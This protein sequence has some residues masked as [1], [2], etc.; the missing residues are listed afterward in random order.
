MSSTA[1]KKD[2]RRL[3]LESWPAVTASDLLQG[4]PDVWLAEGLPAPK[5][6]E[7]V[8]LATVGRLVRYGQSVV[9]HLPISREATLPRLAFYLHRLR[10]DAAQGLIRSPWLNR[11]GIACRADLL[12]F[13]RPRAMLRD[14]VTSTVMRPAMVSANTILEPAEFQ[15]TLLIDGHGDLLGILNM[16]EARSRP[17]AIVVDISAQGCG[18]DAPSLI[19]ALPT[20]FTKVP[21]VALGHTGQASE[22]LP[23]LHVWNVRLGDAVSLSSAPRPAQAMAVE[24]IAARDPV[25][26]DF[27]RRLGYLVWNLKRMMEDAGGRTPELAALGMVDRVLRCLNLPLTAHEEGTSRHARGGRFAVR[28]L[29]SWLEIGSR[30]RGRRGDIQ[31]L[32]DEILGLIQF[33]LKQLRDATPGR[34]E[35]LLQFGSDALKDRKALSILVGNKRD[36]FILQNWME[37]KL[38]AEAVDRV[39]VSAMDGVTAV[40]PDHPNVVVF[41]APLFPSRLHWLGVA[42]GRKVVLCHPFE[43]ERVCQQVDRWWRSNALTSARAG[44]KYRIWNLSWTSQTPLQDVLVEDGAGSETFVSYEERPFDGRYPQPLRVAQLEVSRRYDDWLQA[45]LVE[46]AHNEARLDEETTTDGNRDMVILRLEGQTEPLR[47]PVDRQIMRLEGEAF[48][49]CLPRELVVG[50]DLV[51]LSNSEERVATQ[52]ELFDMFVD[53]N[54]GL[55]QTLCVAEKWQ[56]YVDQCVVKV[57]TIAEL[58]RHLRSRNVNITAGAVQHWH[59]GRVIGPQDPAAIRVLADLAEVPSASK[60]AKMLEN[61]IDTIRGEHRKI[62]SDLRKAITLTRSRDVAAVQIG[63][64]RFS[65]EIFDSMVEVCRIVQIDHPTHGSTAAQ[66][67]KSLRDVANAFGLRHADKVMFTAACE[68][69]MGRSAFKDFDAFESIL[70]VLIMGFHPMYSDKSISLKQV[71]DMLAV[72]PASYAG[73]MSDM[74][75]GMYET[76]YM[77]VHD[78]LKVDISRH[79]KLGRIFDPRYT[80]RLHF[81]W[82][83]KASKIVVHHAGEHLPTLSN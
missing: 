39:T 30:L 17:F 29:E 58:T 21:V 55:K 27:A 82:D 64:R 2:W 59:A 81:H 52:R 45:L 22:K 9:L 32:L 54:H 60:M 68:R 13:G 12:V 49:M 4:S 65:R 73:N 35:L 15:R 78:G 18:D 41:A 72:I 11:V 53:N 66:A 5:D 33:N 76:D 20:I 62:G 26:N 48:S 75:K 28:T 16:L 36:A 71:E 50:N 24:V 77:R 42:A 56:Q 25:M 61:A 67:I 8:A 38:G 1:Q 44:D 79:I 69:S 19:K 51:L 63:S 6:D 43:Q 80:L 74:T 3:V 14:F 70:N 34:S 47:W 40:P 37:E 31:T 7:A 10:L 57:K 46:P 83:A 23:G